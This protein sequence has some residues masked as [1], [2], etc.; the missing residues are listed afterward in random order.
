MRA[1][2][3]EDFGGLD[4][5]TVAAGA[6]ND[7]IDA[8]YQPLDEEADDLEYQVGEF[9]EKL[10]NLVGIE[11]SP[12]FKRNRISNEKET[13][14]MIL[15]AADYLDDETILNK[16]PFI[17]VD[18]IYKILRNKDQENADRFNNDIGDEEDENNDDTIEE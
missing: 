10:L 4:V 8:A 7:H 13:T 11:D 14:D 17:T 16:L 18:E 1:G 3:Y 12:V 15:S 6:T 5:H 9:L 2:I